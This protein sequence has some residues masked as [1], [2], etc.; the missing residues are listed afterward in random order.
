MLK[1]NT[2]ILEFS[3]AEVAVLLEHS[4]RCT[5]HLPSFEQLYDPKYRID[6]KVP[7]DGDSPT[8][9]DVDLSRVPWGLSLVAD[10][11]VYLISNGLPRDIVAPDPRNAEY[12]RSRVVYAK[13]INPEQEVFETWW[14]R[15]RYVCGGDDQVVNIDGEALRTALA[16]SGASLELRVANNGSY[17]TSFSLPK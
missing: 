10:D 4:K 11:G 3:A 7:A 1:H 12:G 14:D 8:S 9:D 6:G 15:K 16:A 13:G 5:T 17:I 2:N